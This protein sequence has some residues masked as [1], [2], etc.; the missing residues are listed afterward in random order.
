MLIQTPSIAEMYMGELTVAI[1]E[2]QV[3]GGCGLCGCA[4]NLGDAKFETI[5]HVDADP[6]F[7][8]GDG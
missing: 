1:L 3:D 6:V 7:G 2:V 4:A 5:G 8:A